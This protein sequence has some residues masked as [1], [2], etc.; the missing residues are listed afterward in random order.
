MRNRVFGPERL[1]SNAVGTV[2]FQYSENLA[3]I[4][5]ALLQEMSVEEE[6]TLVA[7]CASS[8]R[9]LTRARGRRSEN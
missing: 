6:A 3:G 9:G 7:M 2:E 8:R 1:S 5:P 4:L